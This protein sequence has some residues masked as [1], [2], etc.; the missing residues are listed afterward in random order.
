MSIESATSMTLLRRVSAG[1]QQAWERLVGLYAPLVC[2]WARRGGL[3]PADVD[4]LRQEVFAAVAQRVDSF[5]KERAFDTFRGWLRGVTRN[6]LLEFFRRRGFQP[7][8]QGG[9]DFR[10]RLE[11]VPSFP[12]DLGEDAPEDAAE[13]AAVYRRVLDHI[14]TEFEGRTWQAFWRMAVDDRPAPEVA[15]ELGMTANAVRLAKW[16]VLHRLREEAGDLA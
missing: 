3:Q 10:R 1:D 8:A 9:S 13:V 2:H 6:K 16:R 14:R 11:L 15:A 4:D 7:E 12:P 5:R